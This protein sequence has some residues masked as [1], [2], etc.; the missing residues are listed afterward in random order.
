MMKRSTAII[1]RHVIPMVLLAWLVLIAVT[2]LLT[3]KDEL[4]KMGGGYQLSNMVTYLALTTPRRAYEYFVYAAV[5]GTVIALGQLAQNSELVALQSLGVS[6]RAIVLRALLALGLITLIVMFLAEAWGSTGDRKAQQ[7]LASARKQTMSFSTG[8]SLWIKDGGVFINAKTVV[9][10][11]DANGKTLDPNQIS[12][13]GVRILNFDGV[14]LTRVVSAKTAR[15]MPDQGWRLQEVI[16]QR[17]GVDSATSEKLPT[18]MWPSQLEPGQIAARALRPNQQ[19]IRELAENVRY[20]RNNKLDELPFSAAMWQR[21]CFPLAVLSLALAAA[22]FAFTSLRTG[23]LGR[24]IFTGMLIAVVFFVLQ[25][26]G[27]DLFTTFRWPMLLAHSLPALIIASWGLW[28][29]SRA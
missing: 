10:D 2:A 26:M 15:Y 29:L 13:W 18:L 4:A 1:F 9:P 20:A 24:S 3:V 21:I 22:S 8:N 7:I 17:I 23:G 16:D 19:S 28:R 14:E 27:S 11:T 25:R 6:K 5:F 12:L